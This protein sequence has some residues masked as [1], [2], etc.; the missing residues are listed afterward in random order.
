LEDVVGGRLDARKYFGYSV[1]LEA[2]AM[3]ITPMFAWYDFWVGLFWDA[4]KKRLYLFPIPMFGLRIDFRPKSKLEKWLETESPVH[5]RFSC[6]TPDAGHGR[7]IVRDCHR[8]GKPCVRG[9]AG[10]WMCDCTSTPFDKSVRFANP[11]WIA[12]NIDYCPKCGEY[13]HDEMGHSCPQIIRKADN[14]RN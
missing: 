11:E 4:G 13:L 12:H 8:C 14:A 10:S 1:S 7:A 6:D 3:K 9:S 2:Q 5:K